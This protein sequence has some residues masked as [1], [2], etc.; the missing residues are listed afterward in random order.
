MPVLARAGE[1]TLAR[2]DG[3]GVSMLMIELAR[4]AEQCDFCC[5][6]E[7]TFLRLISE[8]LSAVGPKRAPV[9]T[10]CVSCLRDVVTQAT[11][12]I[13]KSV[14]DGVATF[15]LQSPLAEAK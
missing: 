7:E 6:E 10:F 2:V 8:T 11:D 12:C 15:R 4:D 14:V 1:P 3:E 5:G 9:A 13:A